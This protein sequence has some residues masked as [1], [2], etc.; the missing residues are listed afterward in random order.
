MY[1]EVNVSDL[2]E[3][4]ENR[5]FDNIV[6]ES[7]Q[8]W[9]AFIKSIEKH[10]IIEPVVINENTMEI[11]SGHQRWMAA[12]EL[13]IDKIPCILTL[14]EDDGEELQRLI[15]ANVMR[16][17]QVDPFIMMEYISMQREGFDSISGKSNQSDQST[18]AVA[19]QTNK[20][21]TFVGAAD[22]FV[23]LPEEEQERIKK[24]YS[25]N[26]PTQRELEIEIAQAQK[27]IVLANTK[28]SN[29]EKEVKKRTDKIEEL[30]KKGKDKAEEIRTLKQ[31]KKILNKKI[32]EGELQYQVKMLDA[33]FSDISKESVSLASAIAIFLKTFDKLSGKDADM[34]GIETHIIDGKL[35]QLVHEISELK[36]R[37]DIKLLEE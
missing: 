5:R 19:K 35:N 37:F 2:L 9:K 11:I 23:S 32:K 25:D 28:A 17:V 24:W 18:V 8:H 16:R 31:E 33:R 1:R 13:G 27:D 7:K 29:Y 15:A 34:S 20:S 21:T 6:D 12:K 14:P 30:E 3:H 4:P 26:Q 22:R 10:G 36:T